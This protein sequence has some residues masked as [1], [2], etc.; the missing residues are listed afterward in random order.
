MKRNLSYIF[1]LIFI[2]TAFQVNAQEWIVPDEQSSLENPMDYI[3]SN[4]EKGKELYL[5]NCKSCHGDP[6]KN[7]A[8]PLV[9]PPPDVISEQMQANSEGDLYYKITVGRAAMPQFETVL[10]DDERWNVVN[11]IMN[12]NSSREALLIEKPP[13]KANIQ[14]SVKGATLEVLVE[15]LEAQALEGVPVIISNRKTFGNLK[16]GETITGE[17]GRSEFEIPTNIIGDEKGYVDL[18]VSLNDEY[19]AEALMLDKAM[20]AT[21][22]EHKALIRKGVLWS[23]NDNMPLWLIISFFGFV[24]GAWATIIYVVLQIIKIRKIN[25]EV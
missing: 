25:G 8:L 18:V 20:I 3:L 9:P 15:S 21:P 10:S 6:G 11:Y 24:L 17:D 16:I 5:L 7:N 14:A 19:E 4:V 23:T 2:F 12:Y 1:T 13:V 22:K